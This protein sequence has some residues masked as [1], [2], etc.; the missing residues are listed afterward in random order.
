MLTKLEPILQLI[1][2]IAVITSIIT[3]I[4]RKRYENV[5]FALIAGGL[6]L[7]ILKNPTSLYEVGRYIIALVEETAKEVPKGVAKP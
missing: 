1:I 2:L 7:Y 6:C 4:V 5:A 3:S